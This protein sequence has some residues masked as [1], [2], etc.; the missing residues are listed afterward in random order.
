MSILLYFVVAQ[1]L[2]SVNVC[3]LRGNFPMSKFAPDLNHKAV[4]SKVIELGYAARAVIQQLA[5]RDG[6]PEGLEAK[7]ILENAL[8]DA[9]PDGDHA[10][11]LIPT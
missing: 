7:R 6:T 10:K 11:H 5:N 8:T 4:K 3:A 2:A 1:F 9:V